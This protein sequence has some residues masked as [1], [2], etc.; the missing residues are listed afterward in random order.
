MTPHQSFPKPEPHVYQRA[1]AR[2]AQERA[3]R[4][5]CDAVDARDRYVCRVCRRNVVRTLTLCA[6]RAEHHHLAPR[7]MAPELRADVRNCLCV[8]ASC[9]VR[10]TR[11]EIT[12]TQDPAHGFDHQGQRYLNA[13]QPIAFLGVTNR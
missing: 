12:P 9:H 10:L 6:E 8:C 7:S 5:C 1:T 3:W 4:A 2:R 13:E 11:H